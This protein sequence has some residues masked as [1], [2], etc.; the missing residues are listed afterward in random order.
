MVVL[1]E[2]KLENINKVKE[3]LPQYQII[4]RCIK[5]GKGGVV[6]AVKRNTFGSFINVTNTENKNILVARLGLRSGYFR[7]IAAY[8][9]P[10]N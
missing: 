2:V 3:V 10:R 8:A 1:C 5:L 6:I 7:I 4:D 9:P